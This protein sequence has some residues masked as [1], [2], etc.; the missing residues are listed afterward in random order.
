MNCFTIRIMNENDDYYLKTN[1]HH[2]MKQLE[3]YHIDD[4]RLHLLI[5]SIGSI[6]WNL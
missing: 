2:L 4:N 3:N 1:L 5:F 6:D